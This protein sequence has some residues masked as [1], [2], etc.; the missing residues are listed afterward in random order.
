[1][2]KQP[3]APQ[4]T[5]K[6]EEIRKTV[7]SLS[8]FSNTSNEKQKPSKNGKHSDRMR[9]RSLPGSNS[10]KISDLLAIKSSTDINQVHC[11]CE[12]L[13]N[14]L[15][16]FVND[17]IGSQEYQDY[18]DFKR[19][20][21][22]KDKII[23]CDSKDFEE[24][25]DVP[26]PEKK[27]KIDRL[28][29]LSRKALRVFFLEAQIEKYLNDLKNAEIVKKQEETIAT[30]RMKIAEVKEIFFCQREKKLQ[31]KMEREQTLLT[32]FMCRH[33]IDISKLIS[34]NRLDRV[35]LDIERKMRIKRRRHKN[36][37]RSIMEK[38]LKEYHNNRKQRRKL[39]KMY[40]RKEK[41]KMDDKVLV[42][43]KGRQNSNIII[44]SVHNVRE[45]NLVKEAFEEAGIC[46]KEEDITISGQQGFCDKA[47]VTDIPYETSDKSMQESLEKNISF[48]FS[49]EQIFK[50][51]LDE[52]AKQ[53]L[54]KIQS[55]IEFEDLLEARH[56]FCTC[57]KERKENEEK[58]IDYPDDESIFSN[59]DH[60]SFKNFTVGKIYYK[61]LVLRNKTGSPV[62]IRFF[63]F[64]F[65]DIKY[66]IYFE[67]D[68]DEMK[69]ALPGLPVNL[70]VKFR[71]IKTSDVIRGKLV[72]LTCY[73]STYYRF[74][75]TIECIPATS[76][77][78]LEPRTVS[79]GRIPLWKFHKSIPQITRLIKVKCLDKSPHKISIKRVE[80]PLDLDTLKYDLSSSTS[81]ESDEGKKSPDQ[82]EMELIIR[83]ILKEVDSR[84]RFDRLFMVLD[85]QSGEKHLKISLTQIQHPGF[86][87][88]KY[89]MDV[90]KVLEEEDE[91][92]GMQ[93]INITLEVEDHF[94]KCD[95]VCIDFGIC[96]YGT[97]Y[98]AAFNISNTST[99]S[100]FVT[101]RIPSLINYYVSLNDSNI[102]LK[103]GETRRVAI[104][105]LPSHDLVLEK[106]KYF[107]SDTFILYFPIEIKLNDR[108][109]LSAPSIMEHCYAIVNDCSD[110]TVD[111]PRE[112][113]EMFDGH[114]V[115]DMGTCSVSEAVVAQIIVRNSSYSKR[116]YGFTNLPR[117]IT[118]MPNYGFGCI[119]A[120]QEIILNIFIHPQVVDIETSLKNKDKFFLAR[121]C[122]IVVDTV[123]NLGKY[124]RK[125]SMNRLL[126]LMRLMIQ[127]MRRL[128]DIELLEDIFETKSI[129][130]QEINLC[131]CSNAQLVKSQSNVTV[132]L[133]GE[134][135]ELKKEESEANSN[136]NLQESQTHGSKTS[137]HHHKKKLNHTTSKELIKQH[138]DYQDL[139]VENPIGSIHSGTKHLRRSLKSKISS[140]LSLTQI[141]EEV[142]KEP[143][144]ID[145]EQRPSLLQKK[146]VNQF[147]LEPRITVPMNSLV[148][149]AETLSRELRLRMVF[150]KPLYEFSFN[151]LEFPVTPGGSYS[152]TTTELRPLKYDRKGC[153]PDKDEKAPNYRATFRIAGS[154]E[155]M[156]IEPMYGILKSGES[157]K[158][159]LVATPKM[160]EEV[161]A[162]CAYE[163]K[164]KML[165][166][167]KMIEELRKR[168][169]ALARKT[170]KSKTKVGPKTG[171]KKEK[172]MMEV[173]ATKVED[174]EINI[175]ISSEEVQVEYSD[176]YPAELTL[177]RSIEPYILEN[178]FVCHVEYEM[179][180]P[181]SH[182]PDT[183]SLKAVC[184]VISPDFIHDQNS[185][186]LDFGHVALG[187]SR[188]K[189]ITIQNLRYHDINVTTSILRPEG[190]FFC[191][192]FDSVQLPSECFLKIPITY[193][194]QEEESVIEYMEIRAERT[195]YQ[196]LLSAEAAS[197]NV[198]MEPSSK[199]FRVSAKK[200]KIL[201]IPL[202]I[203]NDS[204]QPVEV[205]LEKVIEL[206]GRMI[207]TPSQLKSKSRTIKKGGENKDADGKASDGTTKKRVSFS[208]ELTDKEINSIENDFSI[209]TGSPYF[210]L[211]GGEE[212]II[213]QE[214]SKKTIKILF[215]PSCCDT[216]KSASNLR[217][218]SKKP[219]I[220][221]VDDDDIGKTFVTKFNLLIGSSNLLRDVIILG[222]IK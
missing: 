11:S 168:E 37:I 218:K 207:R 130:R 195:V 85:R 171:K 131:T 183:F 209:N 132:E 221:D 157:I 136:L 104:K 112:H 194:P 20:I 208:D 182:E 94:I 199:V 116:Y 105:L 177:W 166:E 127:E 39:Q 3:A 5:P 165:Y 148:N 176:L 185:Q 219:S 135:T 21:I 57:E 89:Q 103:S 38:L 109:Y 28:R 19:S 53:K 144:E 52:N 64:Y 220:V 173:E 18:L 96:F 138:S 117:F 161:I 163:D 142:P 167:A 67:I 212:R 97:A 114:M 186:R 16:M 79:F 139:G 2:V 170:K 78:I 75:I 106:C 192:N 147:D 8:K 51:R 10:S 189:I 121:E 124:R 56:F 82:L 7:R 108:K 140:E 113:Y 25:V 43:I 69:I 150:V 193:K 40:T 13:H 197:P 134:D 158:L 128:T 66:K 49:Q 71:A 201:D 88:E 95:P 213:L 143:T 198:R 92:E 72:F 146:A 102:V 156:K 141:P 155:E 59:P 188:K 91:Y 210:Q 217:K 184:K 174:E 77:V 33:Q 31:K 90:Y 122:T 83:D 54:G 30:I 115:L 36:N 48:Q 178:N 60:I 154:T 81:E 32:Y 42:H 46:L 187:D 50:M 205:Y 14:E 100:K 160:N 216:P 17:F 181:W 204:C 190:G 86:Y 68:P 4:N 222:D 151:Y 152:I 215:G 175:E 145:L 149:L 27:K 84:F 125:P 180:E 179:D 35:I 23:Q 93:E 24:V 80:D 26:V 164:K 206:E 15:F 12:R 169:E 172:S 29:I 58:E 1:M 34:T 107:D 101:V 41:D 211:P 9:R 214:S 196:F 70:I 120:F 44:S 55:F 63:K 99:S 22:R 65:E 200:G 123:A 110:L 191:P 118:I 62:K 74:I 73:K 129:I 47:C 119:N 6:S 87:F 153:S 159:T 111:P 61:K 126:K 137:H 76:D 133:L 202:E 203:V 98:Q 45:R 162:A